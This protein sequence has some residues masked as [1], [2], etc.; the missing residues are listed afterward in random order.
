MRELVVG[1]GYSRSSGGWNH[2]MSGIMATVISSGA[3]KEMLELAKPKY[4][5]GCCV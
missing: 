4:R 1:S 3:L 2:T 5:V